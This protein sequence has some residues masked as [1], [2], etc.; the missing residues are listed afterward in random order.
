M[1]TAIGNDGRFVSTLRAEDL[2][3]LLDGVPQKIERFERV[4]DRTLSLAILIDTSASQERTLPGQ[5]L[6]ANSFLDSVMRPGTDRVAVA[7]FTGTLTVEQELTNDVTL[8]RQAIERAQFIPPPGY[9]GGGIVIGSA[10]PVKRSPADLAGATAIWDAI[11][12]ACDDVLSHSAREARRAM[13]VL[14][15]GQD[16]ISKNKMAAAVGRAVSDS[17]AVYAI[18]IGDADTFGIDK[19]ALRRLSE[20]TGG[21]AFFPKKIGDLKNIFA[22]ISQELRTQYEISYNLPNHLAGPG[23]IKVEIVNPDLRKSELQLTYQQLVPRK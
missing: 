10:P 21:R 11:I 5:K 17:I 14:T 23:K 9:A 15:D 12:T 4:T 2:R 19:D 16:T 6:A 3:V 7:T 13:I 8:L 22:E 1:L 20:R 18:G